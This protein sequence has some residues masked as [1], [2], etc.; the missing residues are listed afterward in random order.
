MKIA[1]GANTGNGV[2]GFEA[3][4]VAGAD[5]GSAVLPRGRGRDAYVEAQRALRLPVVGEQIVVAATSLAIACDK[6]EDVLVLPDGGEG[7]RD[8]E[9]AE[10]NDVIS[11]DVQMQ[12]V[13]RSEDEFF[14]GVRWFEHE[15]LYE[16]GDV[17][18]GHDAEAVGFL[19][20]GASAAS[21]NNV[22]KH[23]AIA[24]LERIGGEAAADRS[25]RWRTV[26]EMEAP[27]VFGTL[28]DL[29]LYQALGEV[30]VAVGAHSV[31][32]VEFAFFVAVKSIG[33]L[34]VIE[35]DD[36]GVFE[37]GGGA[38]FDPAFR[39]LPC[40]GGAKSF[41]RT[42][43]WFGKPTFDMICRVLDLPENRG[44]DFPPGG[45]KARIRC[46][47]IVLHGR[48]QLGQRMIRHQ[49]KHMVFHVVIHVRVQIPVDWIHVHGSAVQSVVE[50]VLS[51]AGVLRVTVNGPQ[52]GTE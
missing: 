14:F 13:P 15:F 51:Q 7:L 41:V 26:D 16:G 23:S 33:L 37:I 48:V 30:G 10:A 2:A 18:V 28:N 12:V 52:P 3:K 47:A 32:G 42:D 1:E 4:D 31:G 25:A 27:V 20:A 19:R 5:A 34:A 36:V 49:G 17:A 50:D 11:G 44:N 43:P 6:I 21:A 45:K 38:N 35:A 9:L 29:S 24:L 46:G 22:D 40:M 8:I 39:V